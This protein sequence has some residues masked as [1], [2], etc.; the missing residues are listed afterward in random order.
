M[1]APAIGHN[2]TIPDATG[3][4]ASPLSSQPIAVPEGRSR[5]RGARFAAQPGTLS[6]ERDGHGVAL[7]WA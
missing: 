5:A 2:R 3:Q 4:R 1:V 7:V 6:T